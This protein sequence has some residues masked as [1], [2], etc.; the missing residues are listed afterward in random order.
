MKMIQTFQEKIEMIAQLTAGNKVKFQYVKARNRNYDTF[1][2][3]TS[4]EVEAYEGNVLEVRDI[5]TQKLEKETVY[6]R[7]EVERSQFLL[8]VQTPDNKIKS[9]YDGRIINLEEIKPV[10]KSFL[11]RTLDKLK[12]K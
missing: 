3:T 10:P 6:R 8:V 7:P 11:R 2:C 4:Y 1:P 12:V 5:V 9:F